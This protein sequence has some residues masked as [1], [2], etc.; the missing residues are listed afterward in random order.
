MIMSARQELINII[1]KLPEHTIYLINGIVKE[2]VLLNGE[3][4]DRPRPIYGSG[5]GLMWIADDFDAPLAE[6]NEYME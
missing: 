4:D 6:L 2:F 3:E 1:E 5:K